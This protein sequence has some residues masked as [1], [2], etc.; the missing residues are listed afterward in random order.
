VNNRGL[1][2][3]ENGHPAFA[4]SNAKSKEDNRIVLVGPYYGE[5]EETL[6]IGVGQAFA[7]Y[8][9][10]S[11]KELIRKALQDYVEKTTRGLGR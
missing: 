11:P 4:R 7:Q 8:P 10:L 6:F 2:R 9:E 1:F 5:E 3:Y